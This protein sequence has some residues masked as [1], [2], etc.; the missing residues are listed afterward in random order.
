MQ[1]QTE[2]KMDAPKQAKNAE[3][4]HIV[5]VTGYS[6]AG[7]NTVLH[8]LEDI[9]FLCIN[10]LP[11][12]LLQPLFESLMQ[13]EISSQRIA[14][15]LDARG[16][17]ATIIHKLYRLKTVW[18]FSL[19]IVFV[20][21]SHQVLLKRFQE[22]RRRHPLASQQLDIS[23]AILQ[24]QKILK[25]LSDMADLLLDTDQFTIHQLRQFVIEAFSF[26]GKQ[27]MVVTVTAFGYKYGVP[28]ESN[29]VFDVRFLPNPYFEPSLKPL[30]GVDKPVQEYLFADPS[31]VDY[32]ERLRSFAMYVVTQSCK[33]GRFAMNIAIGCTGGRHRSVAFTHRICKEKIGGVS[34]IPRFRDIEK[35]S[36]EK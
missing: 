17:I 5:I 4:P 11:G 25:P 1:K 6:G 35:D 13:E 19:K 23:E 18:P 33:E 27:N 3:M 30:T 29:L 31:V 7:K 36:Y 28:A 24:E 21:S 16:D 22:T 8:S 9:G 2:L 26:D 15:G 14:L 20:T 10:N 32:W 12:A 34:F